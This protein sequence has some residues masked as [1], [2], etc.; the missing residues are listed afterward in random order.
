MDAHKYIITAHSAAVQRRWTTK[1]RVLVVEEPSAIL[2][3]GIFNPKRA[4]ALHEFP[5]RNVRAARAKQSAPRIT[6][7][8]SL[9]LARTRFGRI[10]NTNAE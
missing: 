3:V 5:H 9:N 7:H 6:F 10:K 8:C 4:V 2:A 1:N